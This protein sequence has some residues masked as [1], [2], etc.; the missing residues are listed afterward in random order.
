MKRLLILLSIAALS[1]TI[2]VTFQNCAQDTGSL[3]IDDSNGK[4]VNSCSADIFNSSGQKDNIFK[5]GE[6][7]NFISSSN[8]SGSVG[9]FVIKK[10]GKV[11]DN[12]SVRTPEYVQKLYFSDTDEGQYE[13]Q[14]VMN[15]NGRTGAC[16]SPPQQFTIRS[17]DDVLPTC[18]LSSSRATGA[19]IVVGQTVNYTVTS[20]PS[21]LEAQIFGD[22]ALIAQG[23]NTP[24]NYSEVFGAPGSVN[25]FAQIKT[26]TGSTIKCSGE[27]SYTVSNN[28]STSPTPTPVPTTPTPTP[29]PQP[30]WC[31]VTAT[32]PSNPGSTT[33]YS[34][35]AATCLADIQWQ[36][37][38]ATQSVRIYEVSASGSSIAIGCGT[39]GTISRAKV[40]TPSNRVQTFFYRLYQVPDCTAEPTS[41]NL[42]SCEAQVTWR[43]QGEPP[44]GGNTGHI[45][46]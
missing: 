25:R 15:S 45:C 46:P 35:D 18:I 34:E 8:P 20:D 27:V 31:T 39:S 32:I 6:V 9:Y 40:A 16:K 38:N 41:P 2:V 42:Y 24:T 26:N 29:P 4:S 11:K 21:G 12:I 10:G 22:G 28:G 3:L 30:P 14:S 1:I 23:S 36:F 19:S 43:Y 37:Y 7:V 17:A 13:F 5:P 33:C 44:C